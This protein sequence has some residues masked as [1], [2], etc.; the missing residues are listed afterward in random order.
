[1]IYYPNF[2]SIQQTLFMLLM[3][4][5]ALL[6]LFLTIE[7][8][9]EYR[10]PR[11]LINGLLLLAELFSCGVLFA[12]ENGDGSAKF[13]RLPPV[14]LWLL[15]IALLG[16]TLVSYFCTLWETKHSPSRES[17]KEGIDNLPDGVCFFDGHGAVRLMNWKMLSVGSMLFG[18][19]IQT[20]DELHTALRNPPADVE[21]LDKAISLYR[22]PDGVVC[23]FTEHTI[24]DRSGSAVTEVLAADV[25]ELYAKQ[26]ELKRENARLAEANRGM[27]WLLDNMSEIVREEEILAMKMRVHDGMGHGILA[28]RKALLQQQDIAA[29][30]ENAARWER[31]V[32]ALYRVNNMARIPDEW[33]SVK[34]RA[35]ELGVEIELDGE[36]PEHEFLRHLLLLAIREC[37]TNCVRHA[38]GSRVFAA[39]ASGT[40][41]ITCVITNNGKAPEHEIIEGGGLSGLRRRIE[42]EGGRMELQSVPCFALTVILPL[43]EV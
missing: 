1:M 17:I 41:E 24:T 43:K 9:I 34:D 19:E 15:G 28:A 16:Y 3:F 14:V 35:G 38:D 26:T 13:L 4:A 27:K 42:R 23:R 29:I 12:F 5:V 7:D 39:L 21:C 18:S 32:D 25:T 20:L 31:E 22:F 8:I 2:G 40:E 37:L 36:L 6:Q 11:F 30:H 33:E 10:F